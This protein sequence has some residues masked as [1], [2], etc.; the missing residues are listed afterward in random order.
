MPGGNLKT[1]NEIN[2]KI[3]NGEAVVVTADEMTNIVSE[4]G[5]DKAADEI[6]VVTTGTFGAMCSSGAFLN[7][8][9]SDPPIKMSKTI[10]NG[11]EAYSGLA[12]VD[13]Y[14]GAGQINQDPEKRFEYG[15]AHVIEDLIHGKDIELIADAYGT[16]CYPNKHVE[17][18][19]NIE[20][21]NEAI[22][23]NP[24]NSYQ[25]YAAAI[26]CSE[27]MIYTY[28]GT[29][30][31]DG[32]NVTYSSAGTLSPLLNDPYFETI[33]I[34]TRIFLCGGEGYIV[35]SGTQHSTE[36]E[37]HKGI[38]K[39]SAGTLMVQGDMK[40]MDSDYVKGV[41]MHNYGPTIFNG[42]G[43]PIPILNKDIAART[44]IS[45]EDIV[46]KIYDYGVS[47]R[48]KPVLGETN[49]K[50]LRSGKIEINGK[51]IPTS[52]LSSYKKAKKIADELKNWIENKEFLLTNPVK[53]LANNGYKPKPLK[54]KILLIK[55]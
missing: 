41:I 35:S 24:R 30:L 37:R 43:I 45:D 5:L 2:Q 50:E 23:I 4:N 11:V 42:I 6:D 55:R 38:P 9:H 40:Q 49:Y 31:S 10:L 18:T 52:S 13:A 8:G 32:R 34:G 46:C 19:I 25:N 20:T 54:L 15:G 53:K 48:N 7:F 36:C 51:E 27:D 33:G 26:N 47:R 39:D 44:A 17:T 14:I 29:L 12:A 1:I 16:D 3:K 21:I 22:M 28:M